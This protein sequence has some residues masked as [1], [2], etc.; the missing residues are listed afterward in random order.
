MKKRGRALAL[1]LAAVL[2]VSSVP[3]TVM[4]ADGVKPQDGTTKEQPFWSGTGGSTRFRIPC[5]V[6]LDD[7]TLVAGCDARWNTGGDG[8]GLD[9]IVSRSTDKGKTWHYTFANYLGDNGNVW[10]GNSTAFID[11]AMATDGEK[12]YMMADLYPAGYALNSAN[13]APVAG[14]SHDENGNILLADARGWTNCWVADRQNAANYTY[15][16]EKND[17]KKSD[18]AY[19][20]KDAEGKT[21]TGYT[22]DAY[23]NIKGENVDT[24]LFESDSPFQVWPTDYLYLTTSEDGGATWSVPSI[25]NMRKE[26]EQ[27]LLVGPGRGMVTSKGRILFTAYEFTSYDRNSV[28]IYSD[29]GG[30]TWTRGRS[31][32][33]QSSEAV[34][35]EANG[36]LYMFTRHGGYYTSEDF[37]AT[38]S[39]RQNMGINYCQ[40]CQLTAITYPKKIDGKTAILFAAPSATNRAAGK[41]FVGLV[42]DDGTLDWKYNYSINGSAYYAYSCLTILPD[43]TIGLLYES[44]GTVITYEDFDIEDVAKGAA[45]G[46]I[47]CTDENG[48]VADVTM[49]SDMSKKLTVNGLKDGAQVKVSSDNENAVTAAYADGKVTLTSKAVTGMEKATVTVESEGEKTTVSVI[50]TD[51]KDYEIVDLRVGDTKTYTDKTGNYSGSALEGLDKDIADVT[52][53]GEDAQAVEKEVKAQLATSEAHFDGAEKSL[54]ECLFTFTSVEGQDNTYTMSAKDGDKTVYVN[55]RSAASAGTVCAETAANIKLEERSDDQTFELLDQTAGTSGNRLYF[56]KDNESKLHFDRN[57]SDHANCRME[58]YKKAANSSA[59]SAIPGYEKVTGLSQI[60]SGEKYLIAAKAAT[61]T[62]YVVNPSAA[63][64]K[65]KHVAKVVEETIPVKQEAAVA[66]GSNAQFNDRGEKKISKC[67]FTFDKQAEEGKYKISATTED[68]QKVYLGPKS[69]ASAQTPLTATEAVITVA[70]TD[71]GFTLV[72]AENSANGGY[73]YFW[74]DNEGKFHFDRNSNVDPNGKCEFELYKKADNAEASE[75]PGYEKLNDMSEIEANGQYLIAM[76]AKDNKYYLLN[77]A[78]GNDKY[79]YVAKVTGEMYKDETIGA[80]TDIAITGKAEGK[81]SVKIGNKT[82]FIFVKNDAEEVTIKI[83]ETYNVPGKILNESEVTKDGIVSL[84]KRDNMPPYKAISEIAEGTYLFGNNSHIM[85]N[86]VS[87]AAGTEKGLGMKAVNFNNDETAKDFMW[88]LT[89]SGDGY[90]MKDAASG[91]YINISGSNVE[92]KETEQVLTIRARANGGF[93][94]STN[95]YYLNNWAGNNNKVAAY[96]SDDNGWSFYKA[97]AGNVVT[98]VK[99]GTVTVKASEGINY[100]ITV[101][102]DVPEVK[103][104][105]VTATV[106]DEAMG[107]AKLSP[108]VDKYKEGTE[109]TATAK[110][111]DESK[112]EFVNWT[113]GDEEV[114]KKAEYKF[115]VDKDMELKANFKAKDPVEETFTVKV[116]ANDTNMGE[117]KLDP[118]KA[119]YAKGEK[120]KAIATSKEGY[121]FVNWTVDGK[122][123]SAEATY[124]FLVEKNVELTAN[125]KETEKP[126]EQFTVTV[127][128]NDDKMGTVAVD[129]V[130]ENYEKGDTVI[131]IAEAKEG[132]EFVNWTS[133]GKVFSDSA[134]YEFAVD[135]DMELT[136]NFKAK[137]EPKPPVT[138]DTFKLNVTVNDDKMGTVKL[139]PAKESY[140]AGDVVTATATAKDGYKFVNWT[141][142]GKEVS[143]K[144]E[145][146]FK[147][148]RDVTLKAN[149]EK[150][151][152]DPK[153]ETP[154]PEDPKDEDKAIQTG[155]NGVSPIIPLAGLALAAGAAVTVLRKKED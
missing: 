142:D 6:S 101:V 39:N 90:T 35:T 146:A 11:P 94:V 88:T 150:V 70:K 110:V 133:E 72:Q 33:S 138:E 135:K 100:K 34:V 120:V 30:K 149:F 26:T 89:K 10:N 84:E 55:Y 76:K 139:D 126:V 91:K 96:P 102:K 59:E 28:A 50:V 119:E 65:Y 108:E 49:T 80:K 22:V 137:E 92:L 136:A 112:Y 37:G 56:H 134:A 82:Y 93:S 13:H 60:T 83:G 117:V 54:D 42:Q 53:T 75:I 123:V 64:E 155:D 104:Y 7:G 17:K 87:T 45:I 61:G 40:T 25:V 79:S 128:A 148:D 38:W 20:I 58:L 66:L 106:N 9:T 24:N 115:T 103:E 21:V 73:L 62:Y 81:T 43:G 19:V 118:V 48:T 131:V 32:T 99:E 125:F 107:T 36:K 124:E 29:D 15:H 129:P 74:K 109:V 114:S 116:K 85:L 147:V 5:L 27:S 31:V 18:S 121:E 95:N 14:K 151:A 71:K 41:I 47:W 8:G 111:K 145:Y 78:T 98:G 97:S 69:A 77:P 144:A 154:K 16:L 4:A 46:N 130:K 23:F 68:G 51:E 143:D 1:L 132:Y 152:A 57:T 52:L 63:G 2:T 105:T 127:K 12:V 141:V 86:T 153:P 44:D 113:V 140:K 67:L 122:A 3:G